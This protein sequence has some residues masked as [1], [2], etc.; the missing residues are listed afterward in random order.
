MTRVPWMAMNVVAMASLV[1]A[2]AVD[3]L[4]DVGASVEPIVGGSVADDDTFDPVGALV[5]LEPDGSYQPFNEKIGKTYEEAVA[6]LARMN[7][8]RRLIEPDEIGD[9]IVRLLDDD[10]TNGDAIVMDGSA[11]IPAPAQ[12]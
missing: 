3:D 10:A 4:S 7:P 8:G 12:T 9:V 11:P 1:V 5:R 6:A 2:C